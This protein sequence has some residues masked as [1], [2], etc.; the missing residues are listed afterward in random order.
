LTRSVLARAVLALFGLALGGC[1]TPVEQA[2]E[3]KTNIGAMLILGP[4]PLLLDALQG[5]DTKIA[6]CLLASTS[7][8]QAL[9]LALRMRVGI[10]APKRP[11]VA[12]KVYE[13]LARTTGGTI[14]VYSPPVGSEGAGRVI[15]VNTGP[16]IPGD[17]HAMRELGIMLISG[18][19]GKPKLKAGWNWIKSAAVMGDIPA[20]EMLK[21]LPKV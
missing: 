10:G 15:P 17:G 21:G 3:G 14:Y 12:L 13:Q 8:E 16:A 2:C 19:A 11:G 9:E 5:P 7:K 18:E 4:T 6:S 1:A 20:Q